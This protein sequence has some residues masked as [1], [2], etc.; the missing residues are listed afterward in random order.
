MPARGVKREEH[1]SADGADFSRH[2]VDSPI[3]Y[4]F[5]LAGKYRQ[6]A[7]QRALG[8]ARIRTPG[9]TARQLREFG[10]APKVSGYDS[11]LI[12]EIQRSFQARIKDEATSVARSSKNYRGGQEISR[13]IPRPMDNVPLL[14]EL[15]DG[16]TREVMED[17]YG[18]YFD[19]FWVMLW[20]NYHVPPSQSKEV[21]AFSNWWHFDLRPTDIAKLFVN[22][23]DVEEDCGPFHIISYPRSRELVQKGYNNR[24]NYGLPDSVMDDPAH[25]VKAV[26]P[27]G[28]GLFSNT[29]LCLH[30]A[31][32]P[33]PGK[34]RDIV[35]FQFVPAE[36]PLRSDWFKRVSD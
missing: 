26:G 30:R 20:R 8:N 32:I 7:A 17:Y 29:E 1:D 31:G 11:A 5:H 27:A 33:A 16:D 23:S 12:A 35:Q 18:A 10:A 2:L 19:I 3:G 9:G 21:E 22:L 6:K 14:A 4:S 25:I 34:S 15:I 28:T 24:E 13:E 36:G